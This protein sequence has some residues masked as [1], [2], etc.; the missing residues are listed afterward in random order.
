MAR[1]EPRLVYT[2]FGCRTKERHSAVSRQPGPVRR[3]KTIPV[4]QSNI[5]PHTCVGPNTGPKGVAGWSQPC[6]PAEHELPHR[7]LRGKGTPEGAT[8]PGEQ[9]GG[10]APPS[11]M[12]SI[13]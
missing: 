12:P 6:P 3:R 13:K 9:H 10:R 5:P 8:F 1:F 11:P 4:L 2:P 7:K